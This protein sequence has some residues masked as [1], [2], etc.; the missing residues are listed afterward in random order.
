MSLIYYN[1]IIIYYDFL[2]PSRKGSHVKSDYEHTIIRH[3]PLSDL[4]H[5]LNT[6]AFIFTSCPLFYSLPHLHHVTASHLAPGD[7]PLE[8]GIADKKNTRPSRNDS[9]ELNHIYMHQGSP[10]L[11]IFLALSRRFIL[12]PFAAQGQLHAILS[13]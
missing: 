7:N 3:T 13:T 10:F 4:V 11:P 5:I 9:V 1:N 8:R 12:H 2:P 6:C